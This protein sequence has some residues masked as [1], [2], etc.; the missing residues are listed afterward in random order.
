MPP[1]RTAATQSP[2]DVR[3]LHSSWS[4]TL[5]H[6]LTC[7]ATADLGCDGMWKWGFE[8]GRGLAGG[9]LPGDVQQRIFKCAKC[10]FY[11]ARPPGLGD[12]LDFEQIH[13][14][15]EDRQEGQKPAGV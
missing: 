1:L 8:V 6:G 10:R 14:I 9:V 7:G 13:R 11:A 4:P 3:P 2:P 12:V 15:A 5:K